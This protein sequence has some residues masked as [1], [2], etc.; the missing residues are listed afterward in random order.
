MKVCN[1]SEKAVRLANE[2]YYNF[3]HEYTSI[4]MQIWYPGALY[5]L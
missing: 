5:L 4:F 1:S 2:T 3:G